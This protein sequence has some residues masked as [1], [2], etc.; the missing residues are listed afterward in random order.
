MDS[1]LNDL[2]H[3]HP[4][5]VDGDLWDWKE[6]RLKGL[7]GRG[8]AEHAE[9]DGEGEGGVGGADASASGPASQT[10]LEQPQ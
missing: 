3:S 5:I 1:Y 10:E 8:E 7:A 9:R 6:W 2:Y 4:L